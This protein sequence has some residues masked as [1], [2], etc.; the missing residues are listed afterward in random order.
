MRPDIRPVLQVSSLGHALHAFVN[1][2]YIGILPLFF[3]FLLLH[4]LWYTH[5]KS[6][7]IM[8]LDAKNIMIIVM[9]WPYDEAYFEAHV[10][11]TP[12]RI[13]PRCETREEFCLPEPHGT[14]TRNKPHFHLGHDSW[15]SGKL[16]FRTTELEHT[17]RSIS[18]TRWSFP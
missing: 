16:I 13:W 6:N 14:E 10:Y 5:F 7:S 8:V 18:E 11:K 9:P 4:L 17:S 2:I 3:C 12:S 15:I 1:R